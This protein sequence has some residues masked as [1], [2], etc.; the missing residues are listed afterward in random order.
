[1]A[2][3]IRKA[4]IG[5]LK[6]TNRDERTITHV[7]HAKA[8]DRDGEVVLPAGGRFDNYRKNPVVFYNHKAS[9][10]PIARNLSIE[11]G[12]DVNVATEQFAGLSQMHP[13]AETLY[14]LAS[15]GFL[16][17]WSHGFV[18]LPGGTSDPIMP[19]QTGRTYTNWEELE[20]SLVGLPS[21]REAVTIAGRKGLVTDQELDILEAMAVQIPAVKG[22]IPYAEHPLA[23]EGMAW[24]A[25]AAMGR[26][27]SACGGGTDLANMDWGKY[28]KAFAWYD[29][30]NPETVGA[31]KLPH[32]DVVGG[33]LKTV[34]RGVMAAMGALL[35][36]RGGTNIP[37]GDRRAVYNHLAKHLEEFDRTPPEFRAY[38]AGQ[39][40]EVEARL[41][42]TRGFSPVAFPMRESYEWTQGKLK[43]SAQAYLVGQGV[44]VRNDKD[45]VV[46]AATFPN[47]AIVGVIGMDRP[48][49][50]DK[51]YN[52]AWTADEAGVPG[53]T[54]E[55]QEIDIVTHSEI[56]PVAEAA[57][58][59]AFQSTKAATE[60]QSVICSKERF[61]SADAART[62]ASDHDFKT[63]NMDETG[64]SYRF[65][66]FDPAQCLPDS[67]RTIS[68]TD[69]V[70]ATI[71]RK[72]PAERTAGSLGR[73]SDYLALEA[74]L[75][76]Y[77]DETET[78]ELVAEFR[79]AVLDALGG[80]EKVG[81]ELSAANIR[82]L[83]DVCEQM[84][85]HNKGHQEC[86][87]K[88][89]AF[90]DARRRPPAGPAGDA[91][92][93]A[94]SALRSIQEVLGKN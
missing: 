31:Y 78:K 81:A 87:Q 59:A 22:A 66:Q 24:D 61:R 64:T 1:M 25:N 16:N 32:H 34:M 77:G 10:L 13:Q 23:D 56:R 68:L 5:M 19:G 42:A 8:V 92:T 73:A 18:P 3:L 21:L 71:C 52:L 40:K 72:R 58:V 53:W 60:V 28:R 57:R 46:V 62:W 93:Q 65:R 80:M 90:V 67:F 9:E 43:G 63:D 11:R 75:A 2:D 41:V 6:A 94:L 51:T 47:R 17:A 89:K 91:V 26:M 38:E 14:N 83:D 44:Q 86:H 45:N 29:S 20:I 79:E 30:A 50:Q 85:Q 35:G 69:G 76:D 39:W 12:G 33:E 49:E 74:V 37:D 54:G 7:I 4:C 48:Y 27:R 15:E 55:P 88:I 70:S 82:M 84:D 36:A